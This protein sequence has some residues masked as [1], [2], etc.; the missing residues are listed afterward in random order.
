MEKADK[1]F[2]DCVELAKAE[3]V[4]AKMNKVRSNEWILE[5]IFKGDFAQRNEHTGKDGKDLPTPIL[6]YVSTN[7]SNEETKST[8]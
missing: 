8:D 7:N 4:S 1:D 5:R 2:S 6:G 3:F